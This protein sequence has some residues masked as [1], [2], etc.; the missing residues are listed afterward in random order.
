[1]EIRN[2]IPNAITACNLLSGC[3]GI[4]FLFGK[5]SGPSMAAY[6][7]LLAGLFDLLDGLVARAIGASS[8]I[9]GQLDSLADLVS[10]G[11]L[12]S[13]ICFT[14]LKA[15]LTEYHLTVH[16]TVRE[17]PSF[18][19]SA[20][21]FLA[22]LIPVFAAV[23]LARF[24]LDSEQSKE[25]KGVPV[26]ANAIFWA[27]I[28]LA[29]EGADFG[30][31]AFGEDPLPFLIEPVFLLAMT[32]LFAFLMLAP[33]RCVSF[34]F[35]HFRWKGNEARYFLIG[36]FLVLFPLFFFKAIPFLVLLYPVLSMILQAKA[37]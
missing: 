14:Y 36:A 20:L 21:P 23:R 32:G 11:V 33:L 31:F 13:L 35:Q 18:L 28:P 17:D 3:I 6:F 4:V 15:G 37:S 1:M 26:P 5:T 27:S 16:L 8:E 30:A 7:I 25:F 34:K 2:N 10:F 12:P 29:I 24:N 22:F 9:G 19:H